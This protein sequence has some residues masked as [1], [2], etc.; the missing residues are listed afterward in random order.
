MPEPTR[1]ESAL[2][3]LAIDPS[4]DITGAALLSYEPATG[5]FAVLAAAGFDAT[6]AIG[7]G[8][9]YPTRLRRIAWTRSQL[10]SWLADSPWTDGGAL[11]AQIA[12][13]APPPPSRLISGHRTAQ[14]MAQ[15]VGALLT[16]P[17]LVASSPAI[18]EVYRQSACKEAGAGRAY[19][20]PAGTTQAQK[21]A[22]R[23]A[24]KAAVIDGVNAR[25]R[26][27]LRPDQDAEADAIAVGMAACAKLWEAEIARRAKAAQK[28][29]RLPA[30]KK[31]VA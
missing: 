29:M 30:T 10:R 21:D 11:I 4:T 24:L 31:A 15:A 9:D 2:V 8:A 22:K 17:M 6:A 16:L 20:A 26:M 23:A 25:C 19:T 12:F 28:K 18:I 27:S 1:S 7:T 13:E 14:A 3:L 5:Q